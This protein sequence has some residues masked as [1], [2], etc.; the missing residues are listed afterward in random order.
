[1]ALLAAV[2]GS[3]LPS[4][5]SKCLRSSQSCA[6]PLAT[7]GTPPAPAAQGKV[8]SSKWVLCHVQSSSALGTLLP[9]CAAVPPNPA[10]GTSVFPQGASV[11]FWCDAIPWS[12]GRAWG[13][14]VGLGGGTYGG[15]CTALSLQEPAGHGHLLQV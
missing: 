11:A 8:S 14:A 7:V 15:S 1:M 5:C 13:A 6:L 9:A 3:E 10:V 4:P 2:E 12:V